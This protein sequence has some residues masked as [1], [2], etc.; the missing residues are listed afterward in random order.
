MKKY[1]PLLPADYYDD[2]RQFLCGI[3]ERYADRCA[4]T[5]YTRKGVRVDHT[6]NELRHDALAFSAALLLRGLKGKNIAIVSENRYEWL[7]AY[8][9]ASSAG[10]VAVC[11]D[12]EQPGEKI[13]EMLRTAETAAA[14][15]SKS[16][17]PICLEAQAGTPS[18]H[19]VVSFDP[20]TPGCTDFSEFCAPGAQALDAGGEI[21]AQNPI[22]P[23]QTASIVYTSGTTSRSKAVM[24]SHIG[25]LHNSSDTLALIKAPPHRSFAVLPMYH[26]YGITGSVL[27]SLISGINVCVN[28]DLKTMIRDMELFKPET[29]IAVPLIAESIHKIVWANIEKSGKK[30]QL[31]ALMNLGRVLGDPGL[32]VRRLMRRRFQGTCLESL[33]LI[34]CGGAYLAEKI[35]VELHAF[36][37]LVL[38]GYGITECSPVVSTNSTAA[39]DFKSVG[40]V[41]PRCKVRIEDG[42]ILVAGSTLMNGYYNRPDLTESSMSGEWFHTG[43]LGYLD[44]AGRLYIT[45]R[46]KNLIVMKNGKKVSPEEIEN[47]MYDMPLVREVVAYG[48]A[49]GDS[50]DDV[51]IAVMVY[52]DPERTRGMSSYDILERLQEHVELINRDLPTYKQI[53]NIN[54]RETEFDKTASRKVKRDAV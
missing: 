48:A 7:V 8:F 32:F 49:S 46:I 37:I 26:A 24:L 12:I 53:Q 15:V 19:T 22:S 42:E 29:L 52:P 31:T 25:I 18:L 1:P 4:V 36:G 35:A 47:K 6:Y 9:G 16:L 34:I 39:Y 3:A 45:G 13:C 14:V 41:M 38:Q 23:Q 20:Q 50:A 54:L 28:G 44:R 11:I 51:Q 27:S 43:D 5:Q 40:W 30:Q 10:C 2:F 33:R 21:L 17:A